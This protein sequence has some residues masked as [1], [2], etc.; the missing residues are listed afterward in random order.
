MELTCHPQ[1]LRLLSE[2]SEEA[3]RPTSAVHSTAQGVLS[4]AKTIQGI[5]LIRIR[6][7][8]LA[9]SL[10]LLVSSATN[11]DGPG[12]YMASVILVV[13]MV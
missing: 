4:C 6:C 9:G 12:R 10:D 8:N 2:E 3:G 5:Q 13:S 1:R 7:T 11:R